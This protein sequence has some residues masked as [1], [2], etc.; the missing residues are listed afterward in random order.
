VE[1]AKILAVSLEQFIAA[2]ILL[3]P[4]R[5]A[6]YSFRYAPFRAGCASIHKLD[7]HVFLLKKTI[8]S[9]YQ[10]FQM[11]RRRKVVKYKQ[12]A[13]M[14]V[15][16]AILLMCESANA[17]WQWMPD[18][19]GGYSDS[20]SAN[21]RRDGNG[22][23]HDGNSGNVYDSNGNLIQKNRRKVQPSVGQS[24]ESARSWETNR[25]GNCALA[26][27]LIA[28]GHTSDDYQRRYIDKC[29]GITF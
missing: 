14:L 7:A 20:W 15:A 19:C 23:M 2:N 18:V 21:C 28:T 8:C 26:R 3:T 16:S 22:N 27:D 17:Q 29:R 24:E 5:Y 25:A 13:F 1:Y 12:S 11:I 6:L 10:I 4:L 9:F